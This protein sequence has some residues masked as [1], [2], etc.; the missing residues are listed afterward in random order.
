MLCYA[1]CFLVSIFQCVPPAKLWNPAKP[2]KCINYKIFS[3]IISG[4]NFLS[5]LL[6]LIFTLVCIWELKMSTRRKKGIS[7]IFLVGSLA[8][9]ASTVRI[10]YGGFWLGTQDDT[11]VLSQIAMCSTGELTAGIIAGNAVVSPRF[12]STY[13]TKVAS[14]FSSFRSNSRYDEHS[15]DGSPDE[16][17]SSKALRVQIPRSEKTVAVGHTELSEEGY[18]TTPL[19]SHEPGQASV[20][21]KI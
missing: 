15:Y 12:F 1:A 4:F 10:A 20:W 19:S 18:R 21:D 16:V 6:M 17:S 2:G 14:I 3:L 8:L 11:F 13:S 9:V 7:A 5:D